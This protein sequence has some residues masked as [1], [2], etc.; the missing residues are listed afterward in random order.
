MCV[1][2]CRRWDDE[3]YQ[4]G[5]LVMTAATTKGWEDGIQYDWGIRKKGDNRA[6]GRIAKKGSRDD[7]IGLHVTRNDSCSVG[8]HSVDGPGTFDGTRGGLKHEKT[9]TTTEYIYFWIYTIV[10]HIW[11]CIRYII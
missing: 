1:R 8:T 6:A 2:V 9:S 11:A 5:E 4:T 7:N 10:T 3:M